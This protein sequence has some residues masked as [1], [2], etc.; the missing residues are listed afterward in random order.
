MLNW[1]ESELRIS[2]LPLVDIASA[3]NSVG[4]HVMHCGHRM[5]LW[6]EPFYENHPCYSDDGF[7]LGS[8]KVH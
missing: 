4:V 3:R 7:R 2:C 8:S 6:R 5:P 1:G